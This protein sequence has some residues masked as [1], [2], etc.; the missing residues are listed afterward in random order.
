MWIVILTSADDDRKAAIGP[1]ESFDE[2]HDWMPAL[3]YGEC[4]ILELRS[5]EE[6]DR[7]GL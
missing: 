4:V 6:F 2:A 5:R 7:N 1:F 3:H